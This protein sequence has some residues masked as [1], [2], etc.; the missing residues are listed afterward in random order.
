MSSSAEKVK[1]NNVFLTSEKYLEGTPVSL[2]G[3]GQD[4][5]ALEINIYEHINLP[6]LT[7][8][9]QFQDE[10]DIFRTMGIDGTERLTF[11]FSSPL[12][13]FPPLSKTFVVT[14]VVPIKKNDYTSVLSMS[15]IDEAG[16]YDR[17]KKISRSYRGVGEEIINVMLGDNLGKKLY[18]D[19]SLFLPS[20]QKP[21]SYIVPYQTTYNAIEFVKRRMTTTNGLP[22]FCYASI[23]T[24]DIILTDMESIIS[25]GP[26]N[27]GNPFTFSQGTTNNPNNDLRNQIFNINTHES[28]SSEDTLNLAMSGG[29]GTKYTYINFTSGEVTTDNLNILDHINNL[30][31]YDVI[32][33]D[34]T[35]PLVNRDFRPDPQDLDGK[36]ITEYNSSVVVGLGASTYPFG[37]DNYSEFN[38]FHDYSLLITKNAILTHLDKTKYTINVPGLAFL[39]GDVNTSVGN[40]I[41]V[42]VMKNNDVPNSTNPIDEKKSGNYIMLA[43]RHKFDITAETH[44][45]A[46][47]ISRFTN[48]DPI[49]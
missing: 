16:Y 11:E 12:D 29:L 39:T 43:K 45:V 32:P 20:V 25:R 33:S 21:M 28:V 27:E 48:L 24:D 14:R 3:T 9:I 1:I 46:I 18:E 31:Q 6:F 36:N 49:T 38:S 35:Q 2:A 8:S 22:Y 7:G 41:S 5:L 10:H 23:N 17:V 4:P 15:F 19:D 40:L 30:V 37:P 26:F 44:T 13:D 42:N 47:D 34:Q